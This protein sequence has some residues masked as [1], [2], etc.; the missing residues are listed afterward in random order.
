VIPAAVQ[1]EGSY[2]GDWG[3]FLDEHGKVCGL[4]LRCLL[5]HVPK[6]S[7]FL[8]ASNTRTEEYSDL[9]VALEDNRLAE[10]EGCGFLPINRVTSSDGREI[11]ELSGYGLGLKLPPAILTYCRA[12]AGLVSSIAGSCPHCHRVSPATGC[13]SIAVLTEGCLGSNDRLGAI[14]A[15]RMRTGWGVMKAKRFVDGV[16]V[17]QPPDLPGWTTGRVRN[18]AGRRSCSLCAGQTL[19]AGVCRRCG[20]PSAEAGCDLA[21]ATARQFLSHSDV[22]GAAIAVSNV[23]R[24]ETFEALHYVEA[25]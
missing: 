10:L 13:D 12:C 16:S 2:C 3:G 9:L 25:L 19:K 1:E 18:R 11:L 21:V 5:W 4:R 8:R 24:W 7:E 15:V 20:H 17:G 6:E 22:F 14:T 23:T